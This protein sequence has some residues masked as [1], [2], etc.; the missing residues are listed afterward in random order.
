MV[1]EIMQVPEFCFAESIGAECASVCPLGSCSRDMEAEG[2]SMSFYPQY[3]RVLK[4]E[5][6]EGFLFVCLF[7][8]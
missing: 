8:K 4:S 3:P 6:T 2:S 5:N 7:L 1:P